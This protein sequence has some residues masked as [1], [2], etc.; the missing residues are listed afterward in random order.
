[1]KVKLIATDLDDTLL[2]KGGTISEYT[3]NVV[4]EVKKRGIIMAA[5]TGRMFESAMNHIRHMEFED[6]IICAN[7]ALVREL[8]S[9]KVLL[10]RPLS[11]EKY[12]TLLDLAQSKSWPLIACYNDQMYSDS[13]N[14]FLIKYRD[15]YLHD[16]LNAVRIN[17]VGAEFFRAIFQ[18][19][20]ILLIIEAPEIYVAQEFLRKIY[21]AE[22][23][24]AISK[25]PCLELTDKS[26]T[27][28][29]ALTWLAGYYGLTMSEV[30]AFGDSYND[31]D[32]I[33]NAGTGVAV[34]NAVPELLAVADCVTLSNDEDGVANYIEKNILK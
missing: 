5:C 9:D 25:P 32:M 16:E 18:P 3:E 26:A 20:K 7:G 31:F 2:G 21:G 28:G 11:I 4:R 13:W 23:E 27:K 14:E 12:Q 19:E 29:Q 30:L 8:K 1:M 10:H 22:Y 33:K 17:I 6:V 34:A 15:K 24:I